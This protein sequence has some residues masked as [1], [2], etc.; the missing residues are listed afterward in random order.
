MNISSRVWDTLELCEATLDDNRLHD[1]NG[2]CS[3][4]GKKTDVQL[5]IVKVP[6]EENF[7]H[8]VCDG[9]LAILE[10]ARKEL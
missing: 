6:G 8:W 7:L 5:D 4:C 9:C 1:S 3:M 10:N 2:R